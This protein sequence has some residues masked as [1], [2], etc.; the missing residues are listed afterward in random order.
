VSERRV[1]VMAHAEARRRAMAAVAEAPEGFTVTVASPTRNGAQNALLHSL[2]G[3]IAEKVEWAGKLRTAETWKRL[4]CAAWLR[5]E[6][7]S[8]ELLP[9]LDG[10]GVDFVYSPTS[11][12]SKQQMASLIDYV[13]AFAA[14]A[15][16]FEVVP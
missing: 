1:Y 4:T 5:A 15:G 14:E 10:K 12:L 7:E 16:V 3:E 11:T 8:L 2:L 13:T 6:G 9:A